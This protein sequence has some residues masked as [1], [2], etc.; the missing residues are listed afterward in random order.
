VPKL[1]LKATVAGRSVQDVAR[2]ALALSRAG[3]Q[4]R[5]CLDEAGRDETRHLA[6][7]EEIVESGRTQAERLLERY[8]GPWNGS[9]AAAFREYVF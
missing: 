2:D 8:H 9:V 6:Y 4:R 1:A 7:A 3:L 5:A